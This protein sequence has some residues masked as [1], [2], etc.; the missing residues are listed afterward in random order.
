MPGTTLPTWVIALS[1]GGRP[2]HYLEAE[3]RRGPMPVIARIHEDR[4]LFDLRTVLPHQESALRQA[5]L[6]AVG[7]IYE[8]NEQ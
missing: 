8:K 5:I 3:L 6:A 4:L 1:G 7:A 2:V